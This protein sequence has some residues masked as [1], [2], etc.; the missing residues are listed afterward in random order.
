MPADSPSGPAPRRASD[1][2][3]AAIVDSSSDIIVSKDLDGIVTSWNRAAERILGWTEEDMLGQSIRRIIPDDHQ[4]EEDRILALV[5][6]GERVPRFETER[7]AKSGERIP[8]AITV[9]PVFNAERTIIGASKIAT[10]L[11]EHRKLEATEA[12]EA[13]FRALA[14]N[15]PQLAW[16][17][18][19]TGYI[20]WYNKRWY[21][22]TG[23]DL[24]AM[25]GWGW[26]AVHHDEHVDRVVERFTR[27]IETGTEWED[28]FPLRS[29]AGEFRWFLSRAMP[30]RDPDGNILAWFG[31]N[32]DITQQREH[33]QQIELLMNEVN[34]RSKNMLAVIQAILHRTAKDADPEFVHSFERR[35]AALAA[36]QDMLI[37][38]GWTGATMGEIVDAQLAPV[39][40]M[41]GTRILIG[42][43]EG[44]TLKPSAAEVIGL[45][46]HELLT[47]A[48]KYGALSNETGR[49]MI[50]WSEGGTS[51]A[52][53]FHLNWREVGGPE[54]KPPAR[55]GFGTILIQRNPETSLAADVTLVYRLQGLIWKIDTAIDRVAA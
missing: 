12:S 39:E 19:E 55:S 20:F 46:L 53:R 36:N 50:D 18:D 33:E 6:M 26:K 54:V 7:L 24:E 49:V 17:A 10:D 22:Y 25:K 8:L 34:H 45:A 21:D 14:D 2:Q 3:L 5:R 31:T 41:V 15:I 48:I 44:L 35:I 27:S 38:R 1:A 30:F 40:D 11:R 4:Q 52:P 47:N 32:T 16:M 28:T 51:D 13:R 23:T 37:R 29:A 9:S 43:P 42:G